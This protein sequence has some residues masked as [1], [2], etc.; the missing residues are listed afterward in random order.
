MSW[1][2]L[3]IVDN[4]YKGFSSIVCLTTVTLILIATFRSHTYCRSSS[5]DGVDL[6]S[7]TIYTT[8]VVSDWCI[9]KLAHG[10]WV[11]IQS[12]VGIVRGRNWS[13]SG[14]LGWRLVVMFLLVGIPASG[15]SY[16]DSLLNSTTV[17]MRVSVNKLNFVPETIIPGLIGV[18]R[19]GRSL[20][21]WKPYIPIVLLNPFMHAPSCFV[22]VYCAAFTRNLIH[23][24]ILFSWIYRIL[25]SH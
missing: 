24:S 15:I 22:N 10:W 2:I 14:P 11:S 17:P 16:V 13:L 19:N 1:K 20:S 25:R 7:R 5:S 9:R 6:L 12:I 21:S 4:V 3:I 18:F 8:V 23:Y